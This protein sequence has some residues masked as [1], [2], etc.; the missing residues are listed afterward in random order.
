MPVTKFHDLDE[1][2]RT[3][4]ASPDADTAIRTAL[5]LA[6]FDEATRR[7][8]RISQL[9]VHRYLTIAEAEADRERYA[10]EQLRKAGVS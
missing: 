6:T 8:V 9:G 3:L 5:A 2:A 1:A 10:L 4:P 7:G